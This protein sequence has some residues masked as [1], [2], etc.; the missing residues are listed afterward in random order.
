M[1]RYCLSAILLV[2]CSAVSTKSE[3]TFAPFPD[4]LPVIVLPEIDT[5]SVRIENPKS[6]KR[7]AHPHCDEEFEDKREEFMQKLDCVKKL[8][9]GV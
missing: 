8:I 6:F 5:R 4:P 1:I 3:P 9:G 2:A 7:V